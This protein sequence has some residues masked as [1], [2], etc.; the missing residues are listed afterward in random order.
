MNSIR[1]KK[2][3]RNCSKKYKNYRHYKSF[4]SKDFNERC[5]YCDAPSKRIG[6]K[7]SMHIDHFVPWKKFEKTHKYL[8][9]DYTNLVYA[10]PYC[11]GSKSDDWPTE[12]PSV[13]NK[14][15]VGYIDP[16]NEEFTRIF[17]RTKNGRIIALTPLGEYM[18]YKLS[19]GLRRHKLIWQLEKLYSLFHEVDDLINNPNLRIATKENLIKYQNSISNKYMKIEKRFRELLA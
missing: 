16:C 13:H 8:Y 10:C 5:G 14:G 1:I 4:L 15:N 9:I 12:N 19:L 2:P 6:G 18:H 11:N 3:I 7:K 17:R